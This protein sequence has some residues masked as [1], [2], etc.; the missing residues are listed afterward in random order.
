M[1]GNISKKKCSG[2]HIYDSQSANL[3]EV[4]F[5]SGCAWLI[6]REIFEKCGLMDENYFLYVEDVDYCYRI[7]RAGYKLTVSKDSCI[8]HKE[9][10][11]TYFKPILYYYNTRNRLYFNKKFN[12]KINQKKFYIYFFITR[13][14]KIIMHP[15]ITKFIVKG[16]I[17]YR[18]GIYGGYKN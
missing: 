12:S 2:Y 13:I 5:V 1:G 7:Q 3:K 18:K 16:V 9:S 4:T 8:Y 14:I 11:S 10:K 17:D 15:Q 6:K